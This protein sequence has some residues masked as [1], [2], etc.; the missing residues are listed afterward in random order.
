MGHGTE[1]IL[2]IDDERM[3]L[4]VTQSMLV[5]H[6]Y[7]VLTA[8]SGAEALA[9][10]KNWPEVEVDLLLVDIV[11][12]GMNGKETVERIHALRPRI[13]VLF[14]SGYAETDA[15]R[16]LYP[17]CLPFIAKP[18]TA[19]QLVTKIREVLDA[20]PQIKRLE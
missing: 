3:V 17:K 5:R 6:G 8:L 13:P 16:P 15:A 14:F 18:F 10:L 9:L 20:A 12:P 2:V 19:L 4:G 11:M 1:A 7:N